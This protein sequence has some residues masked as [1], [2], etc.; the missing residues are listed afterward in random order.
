VLIK[1][2]KLAI[3]FKTQKYAKYFY[4]KP[5]IFLTDGMLFVV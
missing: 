1:A 2:A 5:L 4:R 3:A